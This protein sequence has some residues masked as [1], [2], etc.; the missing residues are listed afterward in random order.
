MHR[1][2][3]SRHRDVELRLV[4]L[5]EG[6]YGNTDNDLVNGFALAGMTCYRYALVEVECFSAFDEAATLEMNTSS[7]DRLLRGKARCW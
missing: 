3:R 1:A 7:I 2:S 5:A 6:R 4:S